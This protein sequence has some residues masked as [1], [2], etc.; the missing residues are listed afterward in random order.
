MVYRRRRLLKRKLLRGEPL[1]GRPDNGSKVNLDA[2]PVAGKPGGEM[3]RR[4]RNVSNA[5]W[6]V[7][8]NDL[9]NLRKRG[10]KK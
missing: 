7:S 1:K 6:N 4:I 3:A 10:R 5:W 2:L 8:Q 9:R